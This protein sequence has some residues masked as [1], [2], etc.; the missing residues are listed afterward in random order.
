[1][2]GYSAEIIR[3]RGIE[4]AQRFAESLVGPNP[5]PEYY[6]AVCGQNTPQH[7]SCLKKECVEEIT[8]FSDG[9]SNA[10]RP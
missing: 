5:W 4:A 7:L 1:M 3:R 6:C 8:Q 2:A 9:G 10:E